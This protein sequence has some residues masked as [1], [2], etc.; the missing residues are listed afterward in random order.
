MRNGLSIYVL[1]DPE[2]CDHDGYG[3]FNEASARYVGITRSPK[4]RERQW[5]RG[6]GCGSSSRI[7]KWIADLNDRGLEPEFIVVTHVTGW[8]EGA[9]ARAI[10]KDLIRHFVAKFGSE[11]LL[12]VWYNEP[13]QEKMFTERQIRRLARQA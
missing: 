11:H 9:W 13:Q 3:H 12:N 4:S 6:K 10:E 7:G 2:T 1:C 5:S 8:A